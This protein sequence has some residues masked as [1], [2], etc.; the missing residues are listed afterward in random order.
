MAA[1]RKSNAA[2]P[3]TLKAIADRLKLSPSTVSRVLSGRGAEYRIGEQTQQKV[4]ALA[5]SLNF[6]PNPLAQA[7]RLKRTGAIG[8]V[9]P[10]VSNPF[11]AQL[12]HEIAVHARA[13]GSI[14]VLYDSQERSDLEIESLELLGQRQAD[15]LIICPV[16]QSEDFVRVLDRLDLPVVM[17]D[18]ASPASNI[19]AVYSDHRGGARMAVEHLL[20]AGH[21]RIGCLQGLP[22]TFSNEERLAGYRTA[23]ANRRLQCDP[24]WIVGDSFQQS[25]ARGAVRR[26]V[27]ANLDVTALF[28]FSNLLALGAIEALGECGL[29]IPTDISL[30]GFDDSPY[31]P[32]LTVPLTAVAQDP[33]LL[34]RQAF[35]WLWE[36]I[37]SGNRL[38]KRTFEAPTQLIRRSSVRP[39]TTS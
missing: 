22:G 26:L 9:I 2:P 28:A 4:I 38:Q 7:L 12:A 31:A 30:I 6:S 13:H 18:R 21:R 32:F 27:E 15:G 1:S 10:D 35:E 3:T 36:Q 19:P 5:K 14:L 8:L 29:K 39:L 16:G 25:A 20:D 37:Q 11:F 34:G 23:F 17:V 24:R 33:A